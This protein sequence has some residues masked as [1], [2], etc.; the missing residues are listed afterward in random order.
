MRISNKLGKQRSRALNP[1][2]L[3]S[4]LCGAFYQRFVNETGETLR[5]HQQAKIAED[6]RMKPPKVNWAHEIQTRLFKKNQARKKAKPK[7]K[8]L[9]IHMFPA[10]QK[11]SP[12]PS[13]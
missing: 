4:S 1:V 8:T 2:S 3:E 7:H 13:V 6:A 9:E 12:Q 10:S 11:V 5:L